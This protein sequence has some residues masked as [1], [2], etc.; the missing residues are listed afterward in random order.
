M[1]AL[2]SNPLVQKV[3]LWLAQWLFGK[4]VDAGKDA[5]AKAR[6]RELLSD[7]LKEYEKIVLELDEA[8]DKGELTP[9]IKER[10]R[11]E[12]IRIEESMFNN[13]GN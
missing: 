2:L 6:A 7:Y 8:K 5:V 1:A 13:F 3:L 12:K 10:I 11:R 4:L 9:E